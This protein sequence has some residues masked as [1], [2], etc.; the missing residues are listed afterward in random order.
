MI[1]H[2]RHIVSQCPKQKYFPPVLVAISNISEGDV[3]CLGHW[4][5]TWRPCAVPHAQW[6][7]PYAFSYLPVS[8]CSFYSL[9][10]VSWKKACDGAHFFSVSNRKHPKQSKASFAAYNY[11]IFIKVNRQYYKYRFV[12]SSKQ[13]VLGGTVVQRAVAMHVAWVWFLLRTY[14]FLESNEFFF[15]TLYYIY[16]S[17]FEKHS[18]LK[19]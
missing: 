9:T 6:R 13:A 7:T 14:L 2:G 4:L 15:L 8:L 1:R 5:G 16:T 10:R 17:F 3:L 12:P 18:F 11:I 19:E